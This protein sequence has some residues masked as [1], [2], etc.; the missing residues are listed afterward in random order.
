MNNDFNAWVEREIN[1]RGW[2]HAELGRRASL[3][4][5]TVSNVI[6]GKRAPGCEFC[7]KIAQAFDISPVLVL[8]KAG[9]LPP[10]EPN[11]DTATQ[12]L[13]ELIKNLS[14]ETRDEV[15]QYVRFRFQQDHKSD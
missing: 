1:R 11:E 8:V 14:P 9:M 7:I 4:Q 12:E 15:L 5:A 2:S 10:Q 6:A 13:I 3:A